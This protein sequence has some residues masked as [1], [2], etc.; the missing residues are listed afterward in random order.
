MITHDE[1]ETLLI[2]LFGVD[3]CIMETMS[4]LHEKNYHDS[5]NKLFRELHSL[6]ASISYFDLDE[7]SSVIE[8]SEDILSFL[9][10]NECLIGDD[11]K[12]WFFNMSAQ[13]HVWIEEFQH[14]LQYQN[15]D[16]AEKISFYNHVLDNQPSVTVKN[17]KNSTLTSP[18]III[19]IKEKRMRDN[20]ETEFAKKFKLI[21]CSSSMGEV[22]SML[23]STNEKIILI[24]DVKLQD[25][26][27][28]DLLRNKL[29]DVSQLVIYSALTDLQ[30]E[31]IKTI[32]HIENIYSVETPP[33]KILDVVTRILSLH[34]NS[35]P[36]PFN[37]TKI[38][39]T[40]LT[41]SMKPIPQ[42]LKKIAEVCF[43]DSIHLAELVDIIEQ[44]ATIT[45][46]ILR[47]IN[48]PWYGLRTKISTI[49][50]AVL[51]L[52]KKKTYAIAIDGVSNNSIPHVDVS[53]YG[54][55][56]NDMI[57]INKLRST[58]LE[59]WCY[60]LGFSTKDIEVIIT[61]SIVMSVG[62][63]LTAKA[64]NSNLQYSRFK[65]LKNTNDLHVIEK[66]LLDYSSF[67]VVSKLCDVWHFPE[68]FKSVSKMMPSYEHNQK[69][70]NPAMEYAFII[71]VVHKIIRTDGRIY[72]DVKTMQLVDKAGSRFSN[73]LKLSWIKKF[74]NVFEG[75]F[76]NFA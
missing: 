2:K 44:D 68:I 13:L 56:I 71:S 14:T 45:A 62:T 37:S 23:R 61:I 64:I 8:K 69:N 31:K 5:V 41:N 24:S 28:V 20:L 6:K 21:S 59:S 55:D 70:R 16:D 25:G 33:K 46:N 9:R 53:M 18:R 51:L 29:I 47:H 1:I 67:E 19:L 76:K 52:G 4:N 12:T 65:A 11:V 3:A 15:Y 74:G 7:I 66:Q 58:L 54:I 36:I 40:E 32:L 75:D 63:Y 73:S 72:L 34:T 39:L 38:S 48:S 10:N 60:E 49:K 30:I 27:V 57:A 42:V 35:I 43:D 22:S 50:Q 26:D 17:L